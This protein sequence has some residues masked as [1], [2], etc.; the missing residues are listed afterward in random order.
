MNETSY[1][2]LWTE[3]IEK[4]GVSILSVFSDDVR[5]KYNWRCDFSAKKRNE[6]FSRYKEIH[7]EFRNKY[8]YGD[9]DYLKLMDIHK[10]AACF[11]E[12]VLEASLMSF[13]KDRKAPWFV[14]C[15]NY[16]LAFYSS[17]NIMT[18]FLQAEYEKKNAKHF[19]E[20]K[21]LKVLRYPSTT[22]GHD[23]YTIGRIKSMALKDIQL[24]SFDLLAYADMLYWIEFYNRQIIEGQISIKPRLP[25]A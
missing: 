18:F 17:L 12:A 4:A 2:V 24:E 22:I 15:S 19:E 7:D 21:K 20:Y 11:A 6:V 5:D 8:F 9:D 25:R 10:V 23:T 1:N 13:K 3:G 16:A 14:K